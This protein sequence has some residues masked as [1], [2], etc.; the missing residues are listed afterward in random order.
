MS[1]TTSWTD[2]EYARVARALL[3][4]AFRH[5]TAVAG[6]MRSADQLSFTLDTILQQLTPDAKADALVQADRIAQDSAD[7]FGAAKKAPH[8]TKVGDISLDARQGLELR[9]QAVESQRD[10]LAN[11][12]NYV[13]NPSGSRLDSGG[14]NGTWS[15]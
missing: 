8:V 12:I 4:P 5:T 9:A 13:V 6:W 10:Q 15:P 2:D 3:Y 1:V 14:M 7:Y 11:A